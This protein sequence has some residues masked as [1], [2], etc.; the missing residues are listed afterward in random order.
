MGGALACKEEGVKREG[1]ACSS[2]SSAQSAPGCSA[3]TGI[4]G[5]SGT[6]GTE[7]EM[8]L[9][10]VSRKVGVHAEY[11]QLDD[12]L[13]NA[14][15]TKYRRKVNAA[16]KR[17]A[18]YTKQNKGRAGAPAT[19]PPAVAMKHGVKILAEFI[20]KQRVKCRQQVLAME[21]ELERGRRLLSDFADANER[22]ILVESAMETEDEGQA[23]QEE[24]DDDEV[25][26]DE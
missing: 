6:P 1:G 21:A 7:P 12:G 17:D 15:R 18:S 23:E 8:S 2:N 20:S 10:D 16:L 19:A 13:K 11:A 4:K 3:W 26:D 14:A 22:A 25:G 9:E 24:V 5:P